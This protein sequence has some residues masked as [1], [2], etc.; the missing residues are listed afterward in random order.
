MTYPPQNNGYP[1]QG[2]Q[3]QGYPQQ[4]HGQ[5]GD[6]PNAP[7]MDDQYGQHDGRRPVGKPK[8]VRT[9]VKLMWLGA[10]LSLLGLLP[11]LF[12]QDQIREN[13]KQQA[14]ARGEA[15]DS[16]ALDAAVA[17]GIGTAI[18]LGL[19]G[20]LLWVLHAWANSKGMN[21]AR[22]T[23][24]I[25]GVLY[26][27]FTLGGLLLGSAM[28]TGGNLLGTIISLLTAALAAVIIFLMWRP[29]N[30]AFYGKF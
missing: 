8:P 21:W 27:V 13:A 22:I 4:G 17:I 20:A 11:G 19:I 2:G 1:Q 30:R 15:L 6:F 24:T 12:M 18:V 14:E 16:S 3:P 28:G 7:R 5:Q 10:V 26:I 29:E 9:A 23:G 25:L